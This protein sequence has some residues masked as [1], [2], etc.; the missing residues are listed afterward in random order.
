M[1]ANP[2][3]VA[4]QASHLAPMLALWR[5]APEFRSLVEAFDHG[6][7]SRLAYGLSGS[8]RTYLA[9]GLLRELR[10]WPCVYVVASA[11]HAERVATDLETLLPEARVLT[12]PRA[13]DPAVRCSCPGP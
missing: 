7:G 8:E 6:P 9:A 13:G 2:Q 10:G 11:Q 5:P 4:R 12:I 1:S 3:A